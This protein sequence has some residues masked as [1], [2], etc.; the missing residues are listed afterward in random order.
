MNYEDQSINPLLY[1]LSRFSDIHLIIFGLKL[2]ELEAKVEI[3][4]MSQ[5]NLALV[6]RN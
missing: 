1:Q 6:S 2:R 4:V 3:G 5:H